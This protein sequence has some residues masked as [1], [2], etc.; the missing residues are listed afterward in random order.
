MLVDRRPAFAQVHFPP[1]GES[2]TDLQITPR[3]RTSG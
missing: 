1:E 2:F 3:R